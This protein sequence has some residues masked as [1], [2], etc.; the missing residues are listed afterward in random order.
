LCF[1]LCARLLLGPEQ[2][3]G[4]LGSS[5]GGVADALSIHPV[6]AFLDL[7]VKYGSALRW[8]T[9]I[10]NHRPGKLAKLMARD[11]VQV[12]FSD[13]GA[14]V[15]NMAFYNFPLYLLRMV[16]DGIAKGCA[17]MSLEKA[18]HKLTGE[19]GDWFGV[20]A[21]HLRPGARGDV[22]VV[23]PEGLDG[24][25]D[26]IHEAPMELLG[27]TPRMVRRNDRA[28]TATFIAGELVY[29]RGAFAPGYGKDRRTGTFLRAG[30]R[31]TGAPLLLGAGGKTS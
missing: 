22:V 29:E 30:E 12:S 18:V 4:A 7:V 6:D 1:G 8:K 31:T 20:D 28:V 25:I 27:G 5:F 2:L 3:A 23:D 24:S 14:H 15:R 11:S 19:Q 13:A 17:S 21:G 26:E 10:A 9:T 16:K